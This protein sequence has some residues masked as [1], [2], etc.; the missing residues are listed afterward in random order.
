M[1]DDVR[2][3]VAQSS[4]SGIRLQDVS[5]YSAPHLKIGYEED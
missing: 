5:G 2:G 1:C 3:V 4:D